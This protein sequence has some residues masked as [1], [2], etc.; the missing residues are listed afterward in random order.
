MQEHRF[1]S[2][3]FVIVVT[4]FKCCTNAEARLPAPKR[5]RGLGQ[6]QRGVGVTS[7]SISHHV[8][9]PHSTAGNENR[10]CAGPLRE[11]TPPATPESLM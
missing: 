1:Q 4:G 7:C 6:Q 2:V 10:G 5:R 8:I 3:E 9:Q 11:S